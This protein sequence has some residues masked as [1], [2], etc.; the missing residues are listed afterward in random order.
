MPTYVIFGRQASLQRLGGSQGT[1]GGQLCP[2]WPLPGLPCH[3]GPTAGSRSSI[4]KEGGGGWGA[5]VGVG[6]G[7]PI[8]GKALRRPDFSDSGHFERP[9]LTQAF[10]SFING[11]GVRV[12]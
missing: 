10:V 11:V 6:V 3:C 7:A 4:G 1:S 5:G 12:C 2:T 8:S 9:D